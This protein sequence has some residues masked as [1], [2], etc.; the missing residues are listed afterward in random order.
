[1][2]K[3]YLVIASVLAAAALSTSAQANVAQNSDLGTLTI[4]DSGSVAPLPGISGW[5]SGVIGPN[6]ALQFTYQFSSLNFPS[7]LE[8][9]Y[10]NTTSYGNSS[11]ASFSSSGATSSQTG[12]GIA[13]V[14]ASAGFGSTGGDHGMLYLMNRSGSAI[15][16]KVS[17]LGFSTVSGEQFKVSAVPLPATLG[18]FGAVLLG[19]F[20]FSRL[21]K[22]KALA[23]L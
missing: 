21:R 18:M 14:L 4:G 12:S 10:G 22:Q 17:F 13:K 5:N 2:K 23:S 16:F 11:L 1:M 19:M 20:G 8:I 9:D 3:G 15:D 7:F 6:E